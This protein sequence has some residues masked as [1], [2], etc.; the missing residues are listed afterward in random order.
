MTRCHLLLNANAEFT[1][2]VKREKAHRNC[3]WC[4]RTI[5]RRFKCVSKRF[6]PLKKK[7]V[8]LY[9]LCR[10]AEC[11]SFLNG[12]REVIISIQGPQ[13]TGVSKGDTLD[14]PALKCSEI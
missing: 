10:R 9:S 3:V 5:K 7:K 11:G 2:N 4:E 6:S 8:H 1:R 12:G 14:T 13:M